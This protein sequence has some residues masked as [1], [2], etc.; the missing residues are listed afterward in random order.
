[1]IKYILISVRFPDE[2]DTKTF[3]DVGDLVPTSV[4]AGPSKDSGSIHLIHTIQSHE[5]HSLHVGTG[6]RSVPTRCRSFPPGWPIVPS[7]V[8]LRKGFLRQVTHSPLYDMIKVSTIGSK[9]EVKP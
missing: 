5:Q 2:A 3:V 4:S 6:F 7:L 8:Y 1:M 9:I